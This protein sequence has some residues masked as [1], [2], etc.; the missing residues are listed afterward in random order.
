MYYKAPAAI[1]RTRIGRDGERGGL[2]L[3]PRGMGNPAEGKIRGTPLEVRFGVNI[4]V[5]EGNP[6]SRAQKKREKSLAEIYPPS[7]PCACEVCLSYC[8][9]PGWWTVQQASSAMDAGYGRRMMLEI[10]PD[11]RLG[12]LSPAFRGCEGTFALNQYADRGC[13]F[14]RDDRC[15]LHGTAYQPLEC[16]CCH[17]DR[18][19]LGP[20]CH[21]DLEKNWNTPDGRRLVA[22]WCR[23][24][25]V[26]N[27]L[28]I[29]GLE[30]IASNA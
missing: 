14:L 9:R 19:G 6:M 7:E 3:R 13:S 26:A 17:H 5:P 28:S 16:R 22:R 30:R 24:T 20:Q 4:T 25:G 18:P 23:L 21:A 10:S 15:E 8:R 2:A 11:R 27:D 29:Y 1:K 12:V